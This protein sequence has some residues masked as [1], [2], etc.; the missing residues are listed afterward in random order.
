MKENPIGT[1]RTGVD[2]SR[3]QSEEMLRGAEDLTEALT[4]RF[5]GTGTELLERLEREYVEQAGEIGS[6]PVPGKL[7]GALKSGRKN[8]AGKAPEVFINKLGQRLAFERTGTRLYD[9]VIRKCRTLSLAGEPL[10]F[11]I[12]ALEHI[13][14]EEL[15]HL[16]LLTRCMEDIGADPT[17]MTPDADVSGVAALGYQRALADPRTNVAQSLN[18][19]LELELAD[20]AA[21]EMLIALADDMNMNDMASEFRQALSEEDEHEQLVRVWCMAAND[22]EAGKQ[23]EVRH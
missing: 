20:V 21:W 18:L 7:K 2:M 17:A 1:N 11:E 5:A 13:R 12:D 16:H 10:P 14:D 15:K 23:R 3:A 22:L 9:A 6:V 8:A 4:G 19:L